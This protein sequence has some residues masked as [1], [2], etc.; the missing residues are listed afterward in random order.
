MAFDAIVG[1]EP[2]D[3]LVDSVGALVDE[4]R[5][6]L[7]EDGIR[8]AAVDPANIA[9]ADVTIDAAA[10]ESFEATDGTLGIPLSK[11]GGLEDT[12]GIATEGNLIWFELQE[13][14]R[15]LS[16]EIDTHEVELALIDPSSIRQDPDIPDMQLPGYVVLDASD[17]KKAVKI[18]EKYSDHIL[19][20]GDEDEQLFKIVAEGDTDTYSCEFDAED[21]IDADRIPDASSLLSADYLKDVTKAIPSNAEVH[22]FWGNEYPVRFEYGFADDH[23]SV[24]TV[25]SPRIATDGGERL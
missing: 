15:K 5:L 23:G 21:R 4:F 3:Q 16:I 6:H 17:L 20:G 10:F 19:I 9:M 13:Q 24:E 12:V 18:A 8:V 22:L 11:T 25:I 2:V 7:N 1:N 14:T